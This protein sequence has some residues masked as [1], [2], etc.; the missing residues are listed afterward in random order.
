MKSRIVFWTSFPD[1]T[2]VCLL[3]G[4]TA[5]VTGNPIWGLTNCYPPNGQ[6]INVFGFVGEVA[7]T[8]CCCCTRKATVDSMYMKDLGCVPVKFYLLKQDGFGSQTILYR[9]WDYIRISGF[10]ILYPG[11][12]I[13]PGDSEV[14]PRLRTTSLE[15]PYAQFQTGWREAKEQSSFADQNVFRLFLLY[16]MTL[17]I[18]EVFW[19]Q[20]IIYIHL[21][22]ISRKS[23]YHGH[24]FKGSLWKW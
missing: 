17:D 7:N 6:M 18:T 24:I 14:Q 15:N 3:L 10:R 9:L 23:V 21:R 20:G 4:T 11:N 19:V 8:R 12:C 1:D 16:F 13:L 5:L 22:F 2:D